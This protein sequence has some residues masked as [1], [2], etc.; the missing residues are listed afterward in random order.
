MI[1]KQAVTIKDIARTLGV[2]EATVSL[3]LNHNPLVKLETREKVIKTAKAMGYV[4]NTNARRLVL[5]KSGIIG[6]VVPDIENVYYAS[7]VKELSEG[8]AASGYS[9]SIFISGNDPQK[10]ARAIRDLIAARVEGIV[11][12]PINIAASL[13]ESRTLLD[14]CG[15]P[16]VCATTVAEGMDC[17]LCDLREGMRKLTAHIL[18]KDPRR[19]VYLT[20]P[21]GVYTL[22][23]RQIAFL[24]AVADADVEIRTEHLAAVDYTCAREAAEK[25]LDNLPDAIICVN[26]FMALGVVNL[27]TERGIS[28]PRDCVVT[29]FDD[30]V[31]SIASP[32]PLTTVRQDIRAIAK[33]T[34]ERLL[35]M[36]G[37]KE[38]WEPET[39][40][41]PTEL[42]VRKSTENA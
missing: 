38:P 26:D 17:V 35:R 37:S 4:P 31:F 14:N 39:V 13:D 36:I 24:E 33:T 16:T 18:A 30:S 25:L 21:Q 41:L 19:I 8:M 29:G 32:V 12:V 7:L 2:S 42:V 5:Q 10:E 6:L 15:I 22:D 40:L 11:Y 3:A 34:V 27:L 20:G 23:C 28:V 1:P 9:L